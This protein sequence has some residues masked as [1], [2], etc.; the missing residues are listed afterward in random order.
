MFSDVGWL[1]IELF[2]GKCEADWV[3]IG[4]FGDFEV[5]EQTLK[6]VKHVVVDCLVT[7]VFE[8]FFYTVVNA[9]QVVAECGNHEE[10]LHHAVHV[11]D[12]AQVAKADALLA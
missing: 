7:I 11:A 6:L 5:G 4:S 9:E 10:L 12:A 8:L 2:E 3:I 1:T